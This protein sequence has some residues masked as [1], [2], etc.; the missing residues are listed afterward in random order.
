MSIIEDLEVRGILKDKTNGIEDF[1]KNND[2]NVYCGT[3]PTADSLHVGHIIPILT[4]LRL[5]KAGIK[6]VTF[7]I[8]GATG[9]IGDPSF[10][11]AER[12]F[13]EQE[14]IRQNTLK[15]KNQVEKLF[16]DSN[17]DVNIVN[18]YDWYSKMNV[19]DFLREGKLLTVNY[20]SAKESVKK[21]EL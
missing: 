11:N 9:M 6:N 2:I 14:K 4:L 20:M 17:F 5:K 13:L 10:K 16:K 12:T 21:K 7:L 18:N 8:G 1:I 19:I 15:I 3:D